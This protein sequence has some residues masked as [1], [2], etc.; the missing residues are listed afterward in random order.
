MPQVDNTSQIHEIEQLLLKKADRK[1]LNSMMDKI[2]QANT[3]LQQANAANARPFTPPPEKSSSSFSSSN[4]GTAVNNQAVVETA[5]GTNSSVDPEIV[6]RIKETLNNHSSQLKQL[7]K[8]KAD[9]VDVFKELSDKSEQIDRLDQVKADANIVARKAE[10]EYVDNV[11]EKLKRDLSEFINIT[12]ANTADLFAKDLEYLKGLIDEK[13]DR[14]EFKAIKDMMTRSGNQE[15]KDG[16]EGLAGKTNYRCLS[17]NR[18]M[19]GMRQLPQSMNFDSLIDHL[20]NPKQRLYP[21]KALIVDPVTQARQQAISGSPVKKLQG[22][23][24]LPNH[25]TLSSLTSSGANKLVKGDEGF[26][27]QL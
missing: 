1:E 2:N 7:Y 22:M 6:K 24:S 10:R 21:R 3:E 25:S 19:N 4:H 8:M 15:G 5:N 27:P 11:L 26:L 17:C 18:T 14:G 23:N 20:P 9:K 12:N 13:G 16:A